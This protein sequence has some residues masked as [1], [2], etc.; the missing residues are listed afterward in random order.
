MNI[1][2]KINIYSV[3]NTSIQ[4]NENCSQKHCEKKKR[5]NFNEI[6]FQDLQC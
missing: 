4:V 6:I 2:N 5:K 1:T 3:S